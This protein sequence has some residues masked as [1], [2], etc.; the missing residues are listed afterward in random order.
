MNVKNISIVLTVLVL[1]FIVTLFMQKGGYVSQATEHYTKT[2][3]NSYKV[4][5]QVIE[6]VNNSIDINKGVWSLACE[7]VKSVKTAQDQAKLETKFFPSTKG[8][9]SLSTMTRRFEAT[10][11]YFVSTFSKVE[12]NKKTDVKSLS[13][14]VSVDVSALLGNVPVVVDETDD[15]DDAE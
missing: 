9:T 2:T 7:T 8:T 14:L 12:T 11:Y 15:T 4:A 6:F 13:D 10:P 3:N 5:N 1:A